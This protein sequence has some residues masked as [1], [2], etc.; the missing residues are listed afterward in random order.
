MFVVG[1]P[2]M[3][4]NAAVFGVVVFGVAFCTRAENLKSWCNNRGGFSW[5]IACSAY[6]PGTY[7]LGFACLGLNLR[8]QNLCVLCSNQ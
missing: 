6:T 2:A 3:R 1:V 8:K 7:V 4:S 5:V